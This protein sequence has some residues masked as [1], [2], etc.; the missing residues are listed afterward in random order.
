M[1]LIDKY[2]KKPTCPITEKFSV[3]RSGGSLGDLKKKSTNKY[4]KKGDLFVQDF[5]SKEEAKAFAKERTKRLSPGERKHY[6]LKYYVEAVLPIEAKRL[7]E[8][9][10]EFWFGY[11]GRPRFIYVQENEVLFSYNYEF[12]T[13]S[14]MDDETR[15]SAKARGYFLIEV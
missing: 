4:N 9:S 1:D 8:G 14:K 7:D 6:Q 3:Y 10:S 5:D 13:G 11:N 15:A 2:L 12:P